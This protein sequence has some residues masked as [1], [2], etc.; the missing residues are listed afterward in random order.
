MGEKTIAPHEKRGLQQH[1]HAETEGVSVSAWNNNSAPRPSVTLHASLGTQ[2]FF[3]VRWTRWSRPTREHAR[4]NF[5][6]AI[7]ANGRSR[8]F[9]GYRSLA[10][11]MTAAVDVSDWIA[12]PATLDDK[13][14]GERAVFASGNSIVQ[15]REYEDNPNLVPNDC[16]CYT[17]HSLPVGQLWQ[18]TILDKSWRWRD[19][20]GLVSEM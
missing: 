3:H 14:C 10:P 18:T 13:K 17:S 19:H 6:W 8:P 5:A 2:A 1:T 12:T 15:R 9:R 20:G 7:P 4:N 11:M 16:V